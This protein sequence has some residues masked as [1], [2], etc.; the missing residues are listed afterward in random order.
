MA[1]DQ[2]LNAFIIFIDRSKY[3]QSANQT[4]RNRKVPNNFDH[5]LMSI[6]VYKNELHHLR[7]VTVPEVLVRVRGRYF[8]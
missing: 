1:Q 8:I 4:V 6:D 3:A 5:L 7:V 2:L